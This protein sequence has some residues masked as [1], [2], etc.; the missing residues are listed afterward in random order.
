MKLCIVGTGRCGTT[1]IWQMLNDHPDLFVFRETHWLPAL[2][3]AF[4]TTIGSTEAMLDLVA[5]T[6]FVTG[7]PTTPFD[8]DAFRSSSRYRPEMTVRSFADA[9]GESHAEIHGK[10]F[11]GDK[12]PDYGYFLGPLQ[13]HWPGVRILHLVRD[14]VATAASMSK[15]IGYRGLAAARRVHWCPLSLDYDPPSSPFPETE[16]SHFA[17]LWHDR[18][19]RARDEATRLSPGSYLEVRHEA[20][21]ADPASELARI[22]QFAGLANDPSWLAR[23]PTFVDPRRGLGRVRPVEVLKDFGPR[24]MRLLS[25]L[26]YDANLRQA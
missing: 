6:R 5:R 15:H 10:R 2:H 25:E 19:V 18:L 17:D 24:P 13:L 14:G 26:G 1:L 22:A 21:I 9:L 12:T 7:E 3:D 11:W 23:V 20:V 16:M 4:G 8:V